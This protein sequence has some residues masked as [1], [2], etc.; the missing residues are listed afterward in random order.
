M[1]GEACDHHF[2]FGVDVD[3]LSVDASR[4]VNPV[5]IVRHPPEIMIAPA[6]K[7]SIATEFECIAAGA[8]ANLVHD[9]GG[10]YLLAVQLSAASEQLA[11]TRKVAQ[12][13]VH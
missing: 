4:H 12:L 13:H 9:C 10:N 1:R 8:L 11:E 5:V 7:G 3:R 6:R 2:G